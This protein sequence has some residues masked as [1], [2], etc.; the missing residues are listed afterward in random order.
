MK[1]DETASTYLL[2]AQEYSDALANIGE[3]VKE[4]D[5]VMLVIS[6]L[7]EE[8]NGLKS[9]LLARQAPTSFQDLHGLLAD[10]DFMIK[11][12]SPVVAPVQAFTTTSSNRCGSNNR[13]GRGNYNT[14]PGGTRNQFPWAST[15]N[16]VYGTCNRCGIGHIPSQCPNHDPNT[17]RSCPQPFANFAENRARTTT[18]LPDTGSN[19]HVSHDLSSIDSHTPYFSEDVLHVCNGTGLPI[20]HIGSTRFYSPTKMFSLSNI[21]HVP[22]IK[23]KN[24]LSVQ[25]FCLDNDVFLEVHSSFFAVKDNTTK[26]TLFTGPSNNGLYSIRLPSFQRLPKVAFTTFKAPSDIWH[27]RLRN[28]HPQRLNFMCSKYCLPVSSKI[29]D[30]FCNSCLIGKSSKL[31]LSTSSFNSQ[32]FLDLV[33]C[34][35]W[36]PAPVSSIDGHNYF[37]LCVDDFS[38]FMWIFPLKRKSDVFD[39]FKQ[40]LIITERQFSTKIKSVQTDWGG[41]GGRISQ[42]NS[43]LQLSWHPSPALLPSYK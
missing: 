31:H 38:R 41:G 22:E 23:K 5:L 39:V 13:R 21:L 36:G 8:Y 28:P 10:H 26:V 33:V 27:Q 24:L 43:I 25:K 4:K 32:K 42:V 1:P 2:R 37:L 15:Q 9:I 20:L 11:K 35:V 3:P 18:W 34:D 17:I 7:W 16:T 12:T 19:N 40:F 14:K 29:T 6:G 30:P